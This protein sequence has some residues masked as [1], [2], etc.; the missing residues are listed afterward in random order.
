MKFLFYF[1]FLFLIPM[2]SKSKVITKAKIQIYLKYLNVQCLIEMKCHLYY[3]FFSPGALAHFSLF[4]FLGV[5]LHS[6]ILGLLCL[7]G[8]PPIM[9]ANLG[10]SI[11]C[12][13]PSFTLFFVVIY[14]SYCIV[15]IVLYIV[16]SPIQ[17]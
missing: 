8:H 15:C 5:R 17:P 9:S 16:Y 11:L 14:F 7:A 6:R 10:P 4:I 2:E 3:V 1:R 12:L 13:F